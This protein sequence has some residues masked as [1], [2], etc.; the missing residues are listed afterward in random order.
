MSIESDKLPK[1]N[2]LLRATSKCE[3]TAE[4]GRATISYWGDECEE[5]LS[6]ARDEFHYRRLR[7]RAAGCVFEAAGE[8]LVAAD[9][10]W[11]KTA[12]IGYLAIS[13]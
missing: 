6:G 13:A 3:D 2:C 9:I 4:T 11:G 8:W 1:A 5:A 12:D 10:S 7:S